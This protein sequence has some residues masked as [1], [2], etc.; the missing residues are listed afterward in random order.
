[1]QMES[2][3]LG[4]YS[5]HPSLNAVQVNGREIGVESK[6]ME[7]LV[8]LASQPGIVID[9]EQIIKAV[10]PDTFVSDD[11][12]THAIS[13]L[14]KALNDDATHPRFIQTIPRRGYRLIAPVVRTSTK[15]V[16]PAKPDASPPGRRRW[17][18]LALSISLAA[19]ISLTAYLLV[20]LGGKSAKP[21]LVNPRAIT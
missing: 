19:L 15:H 21:E 18:A 14:R 12:L 13:H 17:S 9:K 11:V 3:E 7:V 1:M 6:A 2:F 4:E 5:V 16:E 20:N 10:W 8:Y